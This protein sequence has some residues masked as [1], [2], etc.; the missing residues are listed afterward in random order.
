MDVFFDAEFTDMLG[1]VC[2]PALISIG[3]VS[4][5]GKEFYAELSDT[6]TKDICSHFV[7]EAVLPFL[8]GGEYKMTEADCAARFKAWIEDFNEDVS[9]RSDAP[10]FDWPWV[11]QLF[12]R[13]G[14][15]D[16]LI[17]KCQRVS[18]FEDDSK[19]FWYNN[20]TENFWRNNKD[21]GATRH[22]AL[23]DARCIRFAW[24]SSRR[25]RD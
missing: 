13:Y 2:D 6:W 15:P 14:W 9:L 22:H 17:R 12:D 4:N 25:R 21:D 5:N 18:F 3:L 23:W 19:L 7:G 10:D 20:A 1:I 11:A 24:S 8:Q 16:N